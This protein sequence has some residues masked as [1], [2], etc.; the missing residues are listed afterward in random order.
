M[1]SPGPWEVVSKN[2]KTKQNGHSSSKLSKVEKKKFAENAPKVE[3]IL[4]LA[5]VKNLYTDEAP[6]DAQ[7]PKRVKE[8]KSKED[9]KKAKDKK[10]P[11]KKKETKEKTQKHSSELDEGQLLAFISEAQACYS[12]VPLAWLRDFATYITPRINPAHHSHPQGN[13]KSNGKW[14]S[15]LLPPKVCKT[16][17]S[18]LLE[19]SQASQL[20]FFSSCLTSLANDMSKGHSAIG[21]KII[22]QIHINVNPQIVGMNVDKL[23]A[24]RN[25]YQ[26][27]PPICLALLETVGQAGYKDIS[28]GLKV[29]SEVMVPLIE[30]RHYTRWV[31][32]YLGK[33]AAVY[34]E[35]VKH[36]DTEHIT[37]S[38][39]PLAS[40][41]PLVSRAMPIGN[42][43]TSQV[44]KELMPSLG[45]FRS[46]AV[47]QSGQEE[48]GEFFSVYLSR[49]MPSAPKV[50]QNELQDG[51]VQ[52]LTLQ[53]SC[54]AVWKELYEKNL[55]QSTILLRHLSTSPAKS[56]LVGEP[57]CQ[58]LQYFESVNEALMACGED[59]VKSSF[60]E[61]SWE[62]LEE[63]S[64]LAQEFLKKAKSS[65]K[66]KG[67]PY[68]KGSFFCILGIIGLII[69]DVRKHGGNFRESSVGHLA[70]DAGALPTIECAVDKVQHFYA[71]AYEWLEVNGPIYYKAIAVVVGPI[72]ANG[73]EAVSHIISGTYDYLVEL[74]PVIM[75]WVDNQVP[76]F[77]D[78]CVEYMCQG[79]VV[80]QSYSLWALE[81]CIGYA[82]ICF[83][84]AKENIFVGQ[85]SAENLQKLSLEAYNMTQ[86]Y[87][88]LTIDWLTGKMQ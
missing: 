3:D 79:W 42:S 36:P 75:N 31:V 77:R 59:K 11:E 83:Q 28:T 21:Q 41:I 7:E 73:I 55:P 35:A 14:P 58:C 10:Q 63:S 27:R 4:P 19:E 13:G 51:L 71:L 22:L 5:Q 6:S 69:Y 81:Q 47:Q 30:M 80:F 50:L 86:M 18:V 85:L 48:L 54:F 60:A 23:T 9:P 20:A 37:G 53:P 17:E 8:T 57:L 56:S 24:L 16:I 78:K 2:K 33:L 72:L 76:G 25:S 44:Q 88:G 64:H 84:W 87:A 67:F 43:L 74:Y 32:S 29:W 62:D 38:S 15:S 61:L 65:P 12:E 26:N 39:A 82:G 45:S 1:S 49:L 40:F 68:I 34:S 52:C 46:L 66:P 70:S